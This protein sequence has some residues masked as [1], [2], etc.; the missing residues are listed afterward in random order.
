MA[1]L[2]A[3]LL[4]FRVSEGVLE[5][6]IVHPG[7][8]F[9]AKKDDGAWSLAKGE[10]EEGEEPLVVACREFE[11]EVGIP[12]PDGERIELGPFK[13]PSGKVITSFAVEANFEVHEVKSN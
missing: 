11:E 12:A 3:A 7:G 9:W 10:Y 6:F 5:L 13:Q 4:P 8:P 1:K 2:S